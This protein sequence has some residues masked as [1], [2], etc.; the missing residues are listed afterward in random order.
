MKSFLS[1]R[2]MHHE[3]FSNH[4]SCHFYTLNKKIRVQL[5]QLLFFW[6]GSNYSKNI[7]FWNQ[8][9]TMA[10]LPFYL[11]WRINK[12]RY[13]IGDIYGSRIA[14]SDSKINTHFEIK[15]LTEITF[16]PRF[17][18]MVCLFYDDLFKIFLVS[19]IF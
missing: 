7:K 19:T 6:T 17:L 11:F 18:L 5:F 12:A 4:E 1:L 9:S 14:W 16:Y 10:L 13:L 3:T 15:A 2:K 8:R